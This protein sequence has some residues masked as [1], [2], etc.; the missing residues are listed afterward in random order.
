MS[1]IF[2]FI[3]LKRRN[4]EMYYHKNKNEI[5]FIIKEK[6]N[7]LTAINVNYTNTINEREIT[8]T[9]RV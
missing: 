8:A 1:C 7:T 2:V 5:D 6:N 9:T 4:K 3:E